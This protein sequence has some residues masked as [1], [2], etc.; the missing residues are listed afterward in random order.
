MYHDCSYHVL[1]AKGD[2][3][4][5]SNRFS[6]IYTHMPALIFALENLV[7][8]YTYTPR[9]TNNLV[10]EKGN[11]GIAGWVPEKILSLIP[12]LN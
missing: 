8:G 1:G 10:Q 3:N 2:S 4:P 6:L 11:P 5:Q 7:M 12:K 9:M